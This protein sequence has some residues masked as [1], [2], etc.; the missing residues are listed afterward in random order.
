MRV[1]LMNIMIM[2]LGM[3]G[4]LRMVKDMVKV[5]SSI[6]L[7][8]F[9]MDNGKMARLM[10]LELYTMLAEILHIMVNGKMKCLMAEELFITIIQKLTMNLILGTLLTYLKC[11]L[12]IKVI[13]NMMQNM[14]LGHFILLMETDSLVIS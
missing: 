5:N 13:S 3:K 7:V 9:M 8:V 10:V 11:G 14:E 4:K 6:K 12:N 2:G 1:M